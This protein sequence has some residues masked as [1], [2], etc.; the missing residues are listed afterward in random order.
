MPDPADAVQVQLARLRKKY[1]LALPEKISG[2]E[3]A[4]AP[5]FAGPWEEKACATA[6]RQIHSL[7]GSSGTYGFPDICGIARASEAL[8]KEC[9]DSRSLLTP[10]QKTQ[11][12]DLVTKLRELAADAARQASA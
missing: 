5:L 11:I 3:A 10:T 2:I 6:Y 7:A 4:F 8:L 1:G 9:L 12:D